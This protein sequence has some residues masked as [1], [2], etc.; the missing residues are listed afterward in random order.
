MTDFAQDVSRISQFT[1]HVCGLLE[2]VYDTIVSSENSPI[3]AQGASMCVGCADLELDLNYLQQF[4]DL[5]KCLR[6]FC[7][8]PDELCDSLEAGDWSVDE[9][10]QRISCKVSFLSSRL[11]ASRPAHVLFCVCG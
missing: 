10:Y 7:S 1:L 6:P 11:R 3:T 8:V 9:V 4:Q 2:K 5:Q